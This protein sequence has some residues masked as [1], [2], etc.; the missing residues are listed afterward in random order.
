MQAEL[1]AFEKGTGQYGRLEKR[2]GEA[3]RDVRLLQSQLADANLVLDRA[4]SAGREAAPAALKQEAGQLKER[5][6]AA[7]RQVDAVFKER[8][9]KA[10]QIREVEA[11]VAEL[12]RGMEEKLNQLAPHDREQY[13]HLQDLSQQLRGARGRMEEE[14]E[15]LN[16]S[17]GEAEGQLAARPIKQCALALQEQVEALSQRK[18]QLELEDL[19]P[20]LSP[21]ER[22]K[23]L[24]A[25]IK[26]DN[27]AAE[28]AALRAREAAES[29]KKLEQR[30]STS[31]PD[32]VRLGSAGRSRAES[33][34]V[35][36]RERHL[37]SFMADFERTRAAK[38]AEQR[39]QE[40]AV[41]ALLERISQ[42]QADA[43][44]SASAQAGGAQA[45]AADPSNP[46]QLA[47]ELA[48]RRAELAK[49]DTLEEKIAG[50]TKTL[51][52]K[53]DSM[54]ADLDKFARVDDLKAQAE[55]KLVQL[56]AERSR[57]KQQRD[58]LAASVADRERGYEAKKA[59]LERSDNHLQ[60]DRLD[61]QIRSLQQGIDDATAFLQAKAAEADYK[62]M[63]AEV[64]NLV[65]ELNAEVRK[66]VAY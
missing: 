20:R 57:L 55:T 25:A 39:R 53:L 48:Q 35:V 7:R 29:I 59:E 44:G 34:E 36:L 14:V 47:Q 62:P 21:E 10:G 3:A 49:I 5:N 45:S 28:A 19:K 63:L 17:L 52:D 31:D 11:K 1:E 18:R 41:A 30:L 27:E 15:Q 32:A 66:A 23:A 56:E 12:Q 13:F 54:R 40:A 4:N 58:S 60:L 2:L 9:Q 26:A 33:D 50:E 42:A 43:A 46:A 37:T 61:Q 8:S 22:R 51:M 16:R 6:A 64:T 65:H 38:Q 24:M